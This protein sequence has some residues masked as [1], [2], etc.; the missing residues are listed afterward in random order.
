MPKWNWAG[1]FLFYFYYLFFFFFRTV[2]INTWDPI[3]LSVR[4]LKNLLNDTTKWNK[5]HKAD[6]HFFFIFK[7][8]HG[9]K[10]P[11]NP[12]SDG[13]ENIT[14]CPIKPGK[15]FTYEVVFSDE[16]G[17]L[18]WHAH[19]DWSRAT[20][21]GAIVISPKKGTSYPFPKPYAEEVIILGII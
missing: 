11:R 3:A 2:V 4:S 6:E 7:N 20:V 13:P 16:E 9:V 18:W 21:H 1:D 15:N 19:S 10:Q 17:T 14:Q 5:T 8:R 12:W